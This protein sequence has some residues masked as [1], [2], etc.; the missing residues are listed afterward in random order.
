MAKDPKKRQKSLARK[1]AKRKAKKKASQ[2]FKFAA[3]TPSL[4]KAGE[5]P[6]LECLIAKNWRDTS[7]ITQ[8]VVARQAD[9][10]HVAVGAFLIDLG[11]LGVK[12]ALAKVFISKG[13]YQR[14]YRSH[15]MQSQ[16]MQKCDLDLAA[17]VIDE[18][19]K[20]AQS[21]GFKPHR[22]ARQALKVLGDANPQNRS[23]TVPLGG[24]DGKP[25]FVAGPYDNARRIMQTLD[26][27]VGEGNY[28]YLIPL[29]APSFLGDDF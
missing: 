16:P 19:T 13:E 10:D 26:R 25:F 6:L 24:E 18:A 22:D 15:V 14:E 20:Y 8:I 7:Q 3:R 21:L 17:K 11:C 29:G 28:H 4:S 9:T 5:W 12:N 23:E 2:P 1:A 27:N